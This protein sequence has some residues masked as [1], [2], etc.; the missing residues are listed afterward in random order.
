MRKG[1]ITLVVMIA[2]LLFWATVIG[3]EPADRRPG[4]TLSGTLTP[5]PAD[6]TFVDSVEEVHVETHPWWGIPSSVT[7]VIGRDGDTLYSPSIYSE[8]VEFPGTKFWNRIIAD[9][10]DVHL[11]VGERLF[12]MELRPVAEHTDFKLGLQALAGKYPFWQQALDDPSKLP[13]MT[14]LRYSPYEAQQ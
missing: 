12:E 14:M 2:V 4:T 13:P 10:P 6:W 3:I 9:N 7:V 8:P 1:M 5:A 11:R